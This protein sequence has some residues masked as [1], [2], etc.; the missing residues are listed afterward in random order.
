[1]PLPVHNPP[2]PGVSDE[3]LAHIAI[4]REW[5]GH[6]MGLF[7]EAADQDYWLTDKVTGEDKAI[8][9]LDILAQGTSVPFPT[10]SVRVRRT[11]NQTIPSGPITTI[12]F[13]TE[14]WDFGDL[15][16]PSS[17]TVINI[18]EIGVWLVGGNLR[19][20]K[21][22]IGKRQHRIKVIGGL[23]IVHKHVQAMDNP[24]AVPISTLWHFAAPATINLGVIQTSGVTLDQ[25]PS[26]D[27]SI[28][29]WAHYL[30]PE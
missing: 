13:D 29:F 30:G 20:A 5:I 26:Q 1:M 14:I 4:N 7:S 6:V 8:E 19:W 23:E 3:P 25:L 28:D 15:W 9:I 16:S 10:L 27:I 2:L 17:P 12:S 24:M 22:L 18:T 21:N 11:T